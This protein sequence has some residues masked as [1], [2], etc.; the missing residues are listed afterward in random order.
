MLGERCASLRHSF[1]SNHLPL[2]YVT[3]SFFALL[4][5]FPFCVENRVWFGKLSLLQH[6]VGGA[7]VDLLV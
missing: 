3:S 7:A 6:G 2:V 4:Q 1:L 5:S